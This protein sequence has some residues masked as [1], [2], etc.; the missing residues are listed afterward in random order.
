MYAGTGEPYLQYYDGNVAVR[1]CCVGVLF[2][3]IALKIS[4]PT[5]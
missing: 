3:G 4:W 1:V 2:D 5:V